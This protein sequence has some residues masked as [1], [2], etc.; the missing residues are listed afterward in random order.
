MDVQAMVDQAM[1]VQA[2]TMNAQAVAMPDHAQQIRLRDFTI[3]IMLVMIV[4]PL[5]FRSFSLAIACVY[6]HM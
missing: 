6:D 4:R 1:D 3:V 5:F 2:V